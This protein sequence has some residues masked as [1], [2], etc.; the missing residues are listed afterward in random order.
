[1]FVPRRMSV[2][3]V[4]VHYDAGASDCFGEGFL[5][6]LVDELVRRAKILETL[7][8][9]EQIQIFLQSKAFSLRLA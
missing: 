5:K 8:T 4:R 9:V 6:R 7:I 1:M 3:S 2:S